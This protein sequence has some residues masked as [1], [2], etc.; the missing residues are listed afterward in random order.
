M[1][2]NSFFCLGALNNVNVRMIAIGVAMCVWPQLLLM[3]GCSSEI[4][5]VIY[6]FNRQ[7]I[8]EKSCLYLLWGMAVC[9]FVGEN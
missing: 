7:Y 1:W 6:A 2:Q 4:L 5:L 3:Y 9:C 8:G